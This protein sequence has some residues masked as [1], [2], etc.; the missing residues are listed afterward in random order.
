MANFAGR[1]TLTSS[2]YIRDFSDD[3]KA[4]SVKPPTAQ[5]T[6]EGSTGFVSSAIF[7]MIPITSEH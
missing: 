3:D 1:K 2:Y 7:I 6:T 4:A 5:D